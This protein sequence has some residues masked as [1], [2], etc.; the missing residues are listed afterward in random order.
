MHGSYGIHGVNLS[1]ANDFYRK[2]FDWRNGSAGCP[3]I[4]EWHLDFLAHVLPL[5]THVNIVQKDKWAKST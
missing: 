4:Q 3:N 1:K 2:N 5:G